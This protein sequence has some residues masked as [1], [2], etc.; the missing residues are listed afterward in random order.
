MIKL[1]NF[2]V[3]QLF[4]HQAVTN[5]GLLAQK[6]VLLVLGKSHPPQ[7]PIKCWLAL[8]VKILGKPISY[9]L[10]IIWKGLAQ[11]YERSTTNLFSSIKFVDWKW[12][13]PLIPHWW[14]VLMRWARGL[15]MLVVVIQ[16]RPF[17]VVAWLDTTPMFSHLWWHCCCLLIE[18]LCW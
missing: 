1:K 5:E 9:Y 4:I 11:N 15:G 6:I 7:R 8:R 16:W 3:R 17:C 10:E 2:A 12:P 14:L 18:R 13:L